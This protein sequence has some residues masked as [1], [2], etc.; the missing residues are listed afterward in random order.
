MITKLVIKRKPLNLVIHLQQQRK[1][2]GLRFK[3][4]KSDGG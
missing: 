1:R 3:H 4:L 2:K